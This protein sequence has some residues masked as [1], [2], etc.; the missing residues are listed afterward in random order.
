VEPGIVHQTLAARPTS[1]ADQA[2]MVRRLCVSGD[3]VEVVVVPAGSGKTFALEAARDAWEASGYTVVGAAVARR[4]ARRMQAS[5]EIESTSVAALQR[6]LR[7]GGDYGL[8][9]RTVVVVEE[10]GMLATRDL[11]EL[12]ENTSRGGGKLV[13][14]GD[15]H[16]LP[17]IDAAAAWALMHDAGRLG[18]ERLELPGGEFAVGDHVISSVAPKR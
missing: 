7:M 8:G 13:L 2:Q 4:A 1:G 15:H 6:E 18:A 10:A 17:E 5:A 3:R 14:V 11:H 9:H 16:Q 12:M